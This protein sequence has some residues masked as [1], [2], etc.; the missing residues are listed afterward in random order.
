MTFEQF[1]KFQTELLF[2]VVKMK[3]TKGKE[4][5]N[6]EDRFANFNRLSKELCIS[7]LEVAYVYVA[8]HLDSIKEAIRTKRF[9]G[10]AESLYR[11][12]VDVIV[13]MTLMAG[14]V[15]EELVKLDKSKEST[16]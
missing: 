1:D 6:S 12:F 16:A 9:D 3:D 8:K 7:N 13:Y 2:E 5:A 11:R 10:R 15:E 14:M 4:Y